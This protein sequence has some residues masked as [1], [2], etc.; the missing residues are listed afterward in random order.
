MS[1]GRLWQGF[2]T[3]NRTA[4]LSTVLYSL[5]IYKDISPCQIGILINQKR[6]FTITFLLVEIVFQ[7]ISSL[8]GSSLNLRYLV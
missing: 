8:N 3:F 7:D 5:D 4:L 1:L 6:I 2:L